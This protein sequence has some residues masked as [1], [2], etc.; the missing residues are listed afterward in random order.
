MTLASSNS[1]LL[2]LQLV[3]EELLKFTC[4]SVFVFVTAVLFAFAM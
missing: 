3:R 2:G 1:L 4:C